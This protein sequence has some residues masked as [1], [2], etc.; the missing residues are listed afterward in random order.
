MVLWFFFVFFKNCLRLPDDMYSVMKMTCGRKK[1][2]WAQP[3]WSHST[4]RHRKRGISTRV[5]NELLPSLC[6]PLR[7]PST[8]GTSQCSSARAGS[9]CRKP[10]WPFP[11]GNKEIHQQRITYTL[12]GKRA[13]YYIY[14]LHRTMQHS[15]CLC[16]L[17]KHF[18]YGN[19]PISS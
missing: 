6:S 3:E 13:S 15:N 18:K 7:P 10:L 19:K 17:V 1:E 9:N 14:I 2:A 11:V 4:Q 16:F 5:E 12:T 8:C